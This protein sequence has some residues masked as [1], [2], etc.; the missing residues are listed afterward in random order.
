MTPGAAPSGI[1]ATQLFA[2]VAELP[3][4]IL[5]FYLLSRL[6]P[7]R[8]VPLFWAASLAL[9]AFTQLTSPSL[10]SLVGAVPAAAAGLVLIAFQTFVLP[11]LFCPRGGAARNLLVCAL[12]GALNSVAGG[13]LGALASLVP[14][15]SADTHASALAFAQADPL[16]FVASEVA[17]LLAPLA[18]MGTMLWVMR[19]KRATDGTPEVRLSAWPFVAAVCLVAFETTCLS[20]T[21]S[22][23]GLDGRTRAAF[24]GLS[25]LLLAVSLL[26]LMGL[27]DAQRK[28][29][30]QQAAEDEVRRQERLLADELAHY[31]S[32]LAQVEGVARLRHDM[33]NQ[34]QMASELAAQGRLADARAHLDSMLRTLEEPKG[35]EPNLENPEDSEGVA[36]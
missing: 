20:V 3:T 6:L 16:S 7:M 26:M 24:Y 32:M 36:R 34:L 9:R 18:S 22:V 17:Y 33:R 10:A 27:V 35:E 2:L 21:L 30:R 11:V 28:Y 12:A 23:T 1:G 13:I 15:T 29:A 14:G 31:G 25:A 8:R 4:D 5:T 19:R